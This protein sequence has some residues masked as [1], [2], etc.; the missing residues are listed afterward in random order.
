VKPRVLLLTTD[1]DLGAIVGA[2]IGRAL[3]EAT[4]ETQPPSST[5]FS[6]SNWDL[7]LTTP[8][9][10][11][12]M[13]EEARSH[14]LQEASLTNEQILG[15][16]FHELRTPVTP[17]L[18]WAQLLKRMS[19]PARTAQA[20][21]VIERNVRIQMALVDDVLDINRISQHSLNLDRRRHDLRQLVREALESVRKTASEKGVDLESLTAQPNAISANV[22]GVRV[23]QLVAYLVSNAVRFTPRG[24]SVTVM[25]ERESDDAVVAVRDT[26][27][28]IEEADLPFVFEPFRVQA[29]GRTH[30][31]AGIQ[32]ALARGLAEVHGGTLA[33]TSSDAG[34]EFRLRLPLATP[35]V[36]SSPS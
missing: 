34:A 12:L 23:K 7:I 9:Q 4:I 27:L 33:V 11:E 19:D 21:E 32:L 25:L 28:A 2:A 5:E 24:G 17:I 10:L 26:G 20:A 8:N 18:A 29:S 3:P 13:L 16:L 14:A 36:G 22:D 35:V 30:G 15:V 31:T 6:S 1:E